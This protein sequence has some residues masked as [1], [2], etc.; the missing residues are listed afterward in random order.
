M[1]FMIYLF[2]KCNIA[3]IKKISG[4]AE[5][6]EITKEAGWAVCRVRDSD[7]FSLPQEKRSEFFLTQISH[8]SN[9][10]E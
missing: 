7:D 4:F 3:L 9:A 1:S 5:G 8:G 6:F 10:I 2:F